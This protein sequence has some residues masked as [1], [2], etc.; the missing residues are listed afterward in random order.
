MKSIKY[1]NRCGR[2]IADDDPDEVNAI[3]C[4]HQAD[5]YQWVQDNCSRWLCNTCRIKLGISTETTSWFY[6]DC[7]DMD[8][9]EEE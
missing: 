4:C 7:A 8:L 2:F 3:Q 5:Y 9:E 1:A 6:D